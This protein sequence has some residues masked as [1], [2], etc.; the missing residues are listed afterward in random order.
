MTNWAGCGIIGRMN[1]TPDPQPQPPRPYYR[2]TTASQRQF[3]FRTVQETGNVSKAARGAHTGRGTYYHWKA[4]HEK[5]GE[6]GL[7][8]EK[9]RAPLHPRIA[10]ISAEIRGEVLAHHQANP[11]DGCRTVADYLRQRHGQRVIGHSKVAE[12]LAQTHA[13]EAAQGAETVATVLTETT[14][15]EKQ[16]VVHA[17][18]AGQTVNIDLC[19]VPLC[20]DGQTPL[21]SVSL[22]AAA[23]GKRV[24]PASAPVESS[25]V[26][27][28]WPGQVFGD[29]T[30]SYEAQMQSYVEQRQLKRASRGQRKHLRRQKQEARAE[31][32]AQTAELRLQRR[33]TRLLRQT[34]DAAW[35]AKRLA[36][37]QV[38]KTWAGRS[39]QERR[40]RRAE[41]RTEQAHWVQDRDARRVQ[42]QQR[43]AEDETW[44]Q[45][46]QKLQAQLAQLTQTTPLVAA[47]LAI[48]VVVDNG[49]RR[50]LGLP[51]FTAGEHVTAEMVV[52]AFRLL[53]PPELQFVISDNGPQFIAQVFAA[54]SQEVGFVHVRIA[55]HRP[56]T[57]GIAERFV[58][59]LK[60]WLDTHAWRDATDMEQLLAEFIVYYNDRPHQGKE[61]AGLSPNEFTSQLL[62]CSRC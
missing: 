22:N 20:H 61:L 47:W 43:Q 7:V 12:I 2:S 53:C 45:R 36:M 49:T 48:L 13:D 37:R 46:R 28:T 17:S 35:K 33:R 58:R 26:E 25:M 8:A 52:A 4:R 44:R 21:V 1:T 14:S 30:L 55:P 51:L 10:P 31:L 16:A 62:D 60:E 39:R 6:S 23:A 38:K 9:S 42:Q 18:Q 41:H 34:E 15:T 5:D 50:C 59:T 3:L 24:E 27:P 56:R 32:N 54:L 19:V 40:Q 57:N 29:Q 11:Q